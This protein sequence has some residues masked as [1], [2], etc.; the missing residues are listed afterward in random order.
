MGTPQN[1]EVQVAVLE[2]GLTELS[3]THMGAKEV[4]ALEIGAGEVQSAKVF[5]SQVR[6]LTFLDPCQDFKYLLAGHPFIALHRALGWQHKDHKAKQDITQ[7][8]A[9][10]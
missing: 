1:G 5:I 3:P 6:P 10:H 2:V 8:T 9:M 4:C 7:A